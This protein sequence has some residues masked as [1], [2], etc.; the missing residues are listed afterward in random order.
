MK[1]VFLTLVFAA[2]AVSAQSPARRATNIGALMAYPGYYHLRPVLL[3]AQVGTRDD[4]MRVAADESGTLPVTS[5]EAIGTDGIN[6]IRGELWDL[7]RMKQ[8]DPRLTSI[9]IQRVF[10]VDPNSTWPKPG[11]AL[12]IVAT[13]MEPAKT[14]AAPSIRAIVLYPT[15]YIDQ[16]VS[17]VGQFEGRNLT[18][19]LPD[20]PGRSRWD[21]VL[22]AADAS[23]WVTGI[24]PRGKGFDLAVD[25]RIDTGRW[26]QVTGTVQQGR[27]LQWINAEAGT[28]EPGKPPA[29]TPSPEATIVLPPAPPPEV[30]FSAPTDEET[31]VAPTTK[32]RIQFSRD[33]DVSTLKSRVRVRY[34]D[35]G[36]SVPVDTTFEYVAANREL[37]VSFVKPLERFRTVKIDFAEGVLGTDKQPLK[38]WSVTFST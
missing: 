4:G 17:I 23:I 12:A 29:E 8:D 22:R 34:V 27:G 24:R 36:G 3:V 11:E 25:Q 15:R 30:V 5:R 1:R 33:I 31:D 37:I 21:F 10:H 6:E 7:G 35:R 13:A 19:D 14:P 16:K 38:T 32:V 20:A 18:G 28:L 26:L 9:E 2:V